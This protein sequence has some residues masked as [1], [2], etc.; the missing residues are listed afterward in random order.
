MR[1]LFGHRSLDI[2]TYSRSSSQ[3]VDINLIW[4]D[5][6]AALSLMEGANAAWWTNLAGGCCCIQFGRMFCFYIRDSSLYRAD[7]YTSRRIFME[8]ES[9]RID[10]RHGDCSNLCQTM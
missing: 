3:S 1:V 10:H 4:D 9:I 7:Y 6:Y 8:I 2:Y 5:V